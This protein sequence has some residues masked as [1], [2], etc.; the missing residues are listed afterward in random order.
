MF[1]KNGEEEEVACQ[2]A[3]VV[4]LLVHRKRIDLMKIPLLTKASGVW[5]KHKEELGRYVCSQCSFRAGDCDFQSEEPADDVEPC[6]GFILLAHL[7]EN[8]LIHA[9]DLEVVV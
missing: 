8:H 3:Q 4:E 6:G 9:S 5:K 2:G 7:K 1:F